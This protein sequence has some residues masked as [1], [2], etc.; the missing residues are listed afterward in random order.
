MSD[1]FFTQFDKNLYRID[2][3]VYSTADEVSTNGVANID[4]SML[5][6]GGS[7]SQQN[8]YAGALVAGKLGFNNNQAGYILG[9]DSTDSKAKLYIGNTTSYINW[10]GT[11]LTIVGGLS[12]S[13]L[14]IP[15]STTANS[16]HVD[17]SGN[18]WW[19][20]NVA[21]GYATAP[22]SI[23]NTGAATFSNVT[24]TGGSVATSTFSGT[25]S[26]S[27]IN[28]AAQGWSQ[29]SAFT[30]TDADT[31]AW[32]AG[33]F[34][35]A[36]GTA[37][38]IGAGNTGNM[39]AKTYIYLDI[40]ISTTAYQITTTASTAVGAGKA[41][42]AIAQNA[43]GEATF[44]VLSGMGGQNIDASSIVANS[45]TANELSTSITYAGSIIIDTAGLIRSGQTAYDTGTGW[46]IGNVAGTPKLSIGNSAGYKLTWDGSSLTIVGTVPDTQIFTANGTWTKPAGALF[47]RVVCIG[48]GGGGGGGRGGAAASTRAGGGGGGGGAITETIFRASDLTGTVAVTVG[49]GALGAGGSSANGSDGGIGGTSSFGAYLAAYGGGGGHGGNNL[50]NTGGGTGG[51]TAGAGVVANGAAN[52]GLPNTG[53]GVGVSGGGGG[54]S[55]LDAVGRPAEYGGGS[56]GGS[57]SGVGPSAGTKG[58][59]SIYGGAAGGG[60]GT[61]ASD[62]N[63]SN[64]GVGGVIGL[65]DVL[66]GGGGAAG[67]TQGGAGTGGTSRSGYGCGDG[68]GGGAGNNAGTG[69]AGGNGGAPGGGGGGGGGGT[70]VGGAGGSGGRGEVRIFTS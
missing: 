69:G 29:T 60:G 19:G 31:I 66:G 5:N 49:T 56:G 38:S 64:G 4:P 14:N 9:I 7:V 54:V 42:V 20:T 28:V 67:T 30:I 36:S 50:N 22:A 24:I 41:L 33:T 58:G 43:T 59:T 6:S 52:G 18:A 10:D 63:S 46:F 17:T 62:N 26:L 15:D 2:S 70:T 57:D 21:T 51:G 53:S 48:A 11:N 3:S 39:V 44:T 55:G 23:L 13:S 25:I 32:G 16:F 45:I 35:T 27:N 47:V 65:Y 1:Q 37:Y 68:G 34:T 12:V 40:A 8:Q 61:T